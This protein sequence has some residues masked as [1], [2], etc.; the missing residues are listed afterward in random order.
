MIENLLDWAAAT[1]Q[2]TD[3]ALATKALA[4]CLSHQF[5]GA[6]DKLEVL[7]SLDKRFVRDR[8]RNWQLSPAHVSEVSSSNLINQ[9]LVLREQAVKAL[10]KERQIVENETG[11]IRERLE[12]I[13]DRL[14]RLGYQ[15]TGAAVDASVHERSYSL[16][17]HL[18]GLPQ[19][20]RELALRVHETILGL[21]DARP[22]FNKYHIAYSTHRRF[23]ML[24]PRKRK[25]V[26][27][28]RADVDFGDPKGWTRDATSRRLGLERIFDLTSTEGLEYAMSL[29]K[30]SHRLVSEG[31]G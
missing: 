2:E 17:Y 18:S 19:I 1:L 22:T 15:P 23:A 5:H 6:L 24:M 7:L 27:L 14:V 13:E 4:E 21:P 12:E 10:L 26:I 25:L 3:S 11:K 31:G 30:Q 28:V 29:I 16:E 8:D 20:T 9:A